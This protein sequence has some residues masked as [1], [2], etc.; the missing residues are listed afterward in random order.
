MERYSKKRQAI[1]DCLR[2]MPDHPTA[3][4][5]YE[6]LR[7]DYPGLSLATVYRNLSRFKQ[8]GLVQSMGTVQ[9]P[10]HFDGNPA[11]HCHIICARC[12]AIAD[13][14]G[15][16]IPAEM[17]GYVQEAT[18]YEVSAQAMQFSG[19]CPRCREK[20]SSE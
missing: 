17:L 1:L 3:E 11:P 20:R 15:T 4:Q 19:L 14:F 12:G 8:S 7:P 2:Q 10:E 9:G 6:R 16:A 13:V 5:I 18:G